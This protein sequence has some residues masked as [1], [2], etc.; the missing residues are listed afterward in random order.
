MILVTGASGLVGNAIF[1]EVIKY[2]EVIGTSFSFSNHNFTKINLLNKDEVNA[3][4]KKYHFSMIIHCSAIIPSKVENLSNIQQYSKNIK[5]VTNILGYISNKIKFINISSTGIYDLRGHGSLNELSIL[6]SETMYQLS[7]QHIEEL[8]QIFYKDKKNNFL[9]IR[10]ASPYSVNKISD[11]VLYKFI[12]N[13]KKD[14]LITLWGSGKRT[15]A[16]TNVDNFASD[17]SILIKQ[18]IFGIY[19]YINTHKLSM[20]ELAYKIK[21]FKKDLK[22]KLIDKEDPEEECQTSINIEKLLK[23]INIGDTLEDDIKCILGNTK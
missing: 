10:I 14:N 13:A 7:K 5:M 21:L 18:N 12:N 11:T 6:K 20:K 3:L 15:Q 23:I 17:L 9:N 1:R 2:N 16:F 8:L 4:F 19:N 22:I